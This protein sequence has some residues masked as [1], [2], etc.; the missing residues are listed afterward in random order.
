MGTTTQGTIITHGDSGGVSASMMALRLASATNIEDTSGICAIPPPSRTYNSRTDYCFRTGWSPTND[1]R[2]R[3]DELCWTDNSDCLPDGFE[4]IQGWSG[5][6]DNQCGLP[7]GRF[8][9][10][11]RDCYVSRGVYASQK[12]FC[13]ASGSSLCWSHMDC[14]PEG[15]WG[16]KSG[17]GNNQCG[18]PCHTFEHNEIF[19]TKCCTWGFARILHI[20]DKQECEAHTNFPLAGKWNPACDCLTENG[21]W[22][23]WN[24]K[25]GYH[26]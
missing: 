18:D 2:P 20:Y 19:E 4:R 21:K 3:I 25:C 7:C 6:G 8:E 5:I 14:K 12:D 9:V 13:F 10:R 1:G 24:N 17:M 23:G 15:P 22:T 26:T 11:P 16:G